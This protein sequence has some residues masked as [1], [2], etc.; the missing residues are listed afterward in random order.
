[1]SGYKGNPETNPQKFREALTPK[2]VAISLTGEPTLYERI[3]ELIQVYHKRGFTTFLVSNGTT[4]SAIA[5]LEEK[6]TQLYISACGADKETFKRVCCP[7]VPKAW[8]KLNQTLELLPSFNCPTV[9]R[10]TAVRGLNMNNV[11]GYARLIARANPTYI[12]PKAYMHVGFSRQRLGYEGMPSHQE[13]REFAAKIA[14]AVS[15]DIIDDSAQSR[16]VLL[17]RLQKPI[18]FDNH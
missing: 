10:I 4:P 12:E 13:I 6:P 17:S 5:E 18:R 1:L 2:H 7:Q 16:V 11:E 15:Y 8:E 9:L 3:G 14:E